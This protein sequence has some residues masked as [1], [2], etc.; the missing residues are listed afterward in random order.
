MNMNVFTQ[1]DIEEIKSR[2][3]S[4]KCPFCGERSQVE[5]SLDGD[6]VVYGTKM[7]CCDKREASFSSELNN[8]I[9]KQINLKVDRIPG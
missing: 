1:E 2:I 7:M 6:N 9:L 5:L 3:E 8:E 4:L